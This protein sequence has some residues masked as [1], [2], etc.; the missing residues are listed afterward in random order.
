MCCL[1]LA[2]LLIAI[3]IIQAELASAATTKYIS[4]ETLV[5]KALKEMT[6]RDE[7]TR[8][9][10]DD[11]DDDD[12]DH[13]RK[14]KLPLMPNAGNMIDSLVATDPVGADISMID[15][16]SGN[17]RNSREN[18]ANGKEMVKKYH[19]ELFNKDQKLKAREKDTQSREDTANIRDMIKEHYRKKFD[20]AHKIKNRGINAQNRYHVAKKILQ[21]HYKN[22]LALVNE[23]KAS[24]N[25]KQSGEDMTKK[26][27]MTENYCKKLFDVAKEI[28]S[29]EENMQSREDRAKEEEMEKEFYNNRIALAKKIIAHGVG[30]QNKEEKVKEAVKEQY[31]KILALVDKIQ[32]Y[33]N[34]MK[35]AGGAKVKE[36]VRE[37]Y[38]KL[39][40]MAQKI[41]AHEKAAQNKMTRMVF[42]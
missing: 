16:I 38:N 11:D 26:K 3:T 31:R 25:S 9:D 42:A 10:K 4:L 8:R 20:L 12:N 18:T 19:K 33:E 15:V 35:R 39:F 32:A 5:D 13:N 28:K 30:S 37:Y 36:I 22:C 1:K 40:A 17:I 23:I 21:E 24:E 34:N 6:R 7:I 41:E 27:E 2:T 14:N 29:H